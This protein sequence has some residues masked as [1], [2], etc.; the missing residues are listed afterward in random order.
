MWK[1]WKK[2]AWPTFST[3]WASKTAWVV[4][5]AGQA[6]IFHFFHEFVRKP[7]ESSKW[8]KMLARPTFST[9]SVNYKTS[10]EI[11]GKSGKSWPGQTF[12]TIWVQNGLSRGKC[13]PSQLF[14][15]FPQICEE[16]FGIIKMVEK[17]WPGQLFPSFS[18]FTKL[19]QKFVEK[20]QKDGLANIFYDLGLQNGLSRGKC[21]P[22][23]LFPLFPQIC[24]EVFGIIK[25]VEKCWP[26]QL[27][28]PFSWFTKLPQ[29][30]VEKVE[31]VGLANIFHDLGLQNGLSRG[32]CWP[33]ELFPLFPQICEEV[34]GIIKMVE[35]CWPGQLFPPFSWF[36]KLPQKFVEKVGLAKHFPRFGSKT[37]WVVENVGQ[38]NFFH[39]LGLQNGLSRGKCWPGQ[40]FP[41]FSWFT[42]LPQKFVE[43]VEKDGLANILHDLGLQN[44]LSRGKCRPGELFPLFPRICEEVFGI[45]IM[46]EKCWPG[47]LF[48]PFSWFTKLPQKFV[49]KVGK[50]GLA[51]IFHH[52]GLQN[53]WS[54]GKCW[55][56]QLFPL[57]P[58]ICEEVFGIVK[59]VEKCWPGQL[60]PPFS[61][62]TKLPQNFVEKVEKDGLANIFHELGLQNGLSCGKCWPGELFPLFPRI[63]EEFFGIIKMVENVGQANFFHHFRGV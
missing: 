50:V 25:M 12:S 2:M 54:S 41:P 15:L 33:G 8:W 61:W 53:G 29:K 39:D 49:E 14:P 59:M 55:P 22:G 6:N 60:F 4:E 17:C 63:C 32:K 56:G 38:A 31:K 9:I 19:P 51:N 11:C 18:W 27:F 10:S 3:I 20:V 57:F 1:K 30:F 45:I 40:L 42:K 34:F 26:G 46:V 58:Q 5:N 52:L 28:P 21:W 37:A 48:P 16:V 44:G 13:W 47:Q 36:T 43:K 7:L 23:E 24:E 62:F 35:K